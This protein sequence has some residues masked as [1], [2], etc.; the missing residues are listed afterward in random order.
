[1]SRSGVDLH[2]F[3]TNRLYPGLAQLPKM[4][5]PPL[6][7]AFVQSPKMDAEATPPA[8]SQRTM[9]P[10]PLETKGRDF[11]STKHSRSRILN[12]R[13]PARFEIIQSGST[14]ATMLLSPTNRQGK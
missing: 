12:T 10:S 5:P 13:S 6:H 14:W 8:N 2:Q 1:M 11:P 7:A 3:S 9:L 4:D